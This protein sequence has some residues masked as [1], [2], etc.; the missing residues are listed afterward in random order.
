[1]WGRGRPL[2]E[3]GTLELQTRLRV[4]P[5]LVPAPMR[6]RAERAFLAFPCPKALLEHKHSFVLTGGWSQCK[7]FTLKTCGF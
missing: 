6:P 4:G 2:D 3:E 1:M 5:G 7:R